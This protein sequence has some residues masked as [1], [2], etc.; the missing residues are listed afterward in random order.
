MQSVLLLLFSLTSRDKS[1]DFQI[2]QI[3][4]CDCSRDVT[5]TV[6]DV[7][8]KVAAVF[9]SRHVTSHVPVHYESLPG[10][11]HVHSA[12]HMFTTGTLT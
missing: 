1:R 12:S 2:L 6:S 11:N 10:Y 8:A 5:A 7:A 4:L 3:L 9:R